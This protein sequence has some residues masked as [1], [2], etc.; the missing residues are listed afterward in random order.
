MLP[1]ARA[2]APP[3]FY[4]GCRCAAPYPTPVQWVLAN[5]RAACAGGWP[6]RGLVPS[7]RASAASTQ[8]C[9]A[10]LSR[11]PCPRGWRGGRS[12]RLF[13]RTGTA[14]ARRD[15]G[16][17]SPYAHLTLPLPGPCLARPPPRARSKIFSAGADN[18]IRVFKSV[19]D[20]D[21]ETIEHHAEAVTCLATKVCG[22][23]S[24]S[25]AGRLRPHLT[26]VLVFRGSR[27]LAAATLVPRRAGAAVAQARTNPAPLC[28]GALLAA[29]RR[30]GGNKG[31]SVR[32]VAVAV[33][34]ARPLF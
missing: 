10:A 15:L 7:C 2:A 4:R 33:P 14:P 31:A 24:W 28:C 23:L 21:A 11:S 34:P 8:V 9:R 18:I 22:V 1:A 13:S 20:E 27:E 29:R 30:A 19:A 6:R 17:A 16:G 12:G 32:F 5:R 3:C 26:R 25:W